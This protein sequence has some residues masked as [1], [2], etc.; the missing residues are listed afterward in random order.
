MWGRA[1][2]MQGCRLC[3]RAGGAPGAARAAALRGGKVKREASFH[4]AEGTGAGTRG[5]LLITGLSAAGS[6]AGAGLSHQGFHVHG[7]PAARALA[8]T[9]SL[10]GQFWRFCLSYHGLSQHTLLQ[11]LPW[12]LLASSRAPD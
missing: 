3:R 12:R 9:S 8:S 2:E 7:S 1:V 4:R 5:F 10:D 6:G 11:E